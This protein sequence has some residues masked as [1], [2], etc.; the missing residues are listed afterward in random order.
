M[1]VAIA[2]AGVCSILLVTAVLFS[3]SARTAVNPG[4]EGAAGVPTVRHSVHA[5]GPPRSE[6]ESRALA[7]MGAARQSDSPEYGLLLDLIISQR[8][9]TA[10]LSFQPPPASLSA[11]T[12]SARRE[13]I[14]R[15]GYWLAYSLLQHDRALRRIDVR[16]LARSPEGGEQVVLF[17][18]AAD[19]RAHDMAQQRGCALELIFQVG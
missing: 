8:T 5:S 18:A 14:M 9:G 4:S 12:L 10:T 7:E 11:A 6:R 1:R 2:G 19:C 13:A 16:A 3:A 17:A 15:G